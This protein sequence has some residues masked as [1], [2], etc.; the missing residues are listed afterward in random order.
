[1]S[2]TSPGTSP[3]DVMRVAQW[4]RAQFEGLALLFDLVDGEVRYLHRSEY[5]PVGRSC[6][7]WGDP[8]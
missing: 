1:M 5:G 3:Y 6:A 2:L 7:D 4:L 8:R